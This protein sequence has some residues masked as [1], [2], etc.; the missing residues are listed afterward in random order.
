V[1]L[2]WALQGTEGGYGAHYLTCL[3]EVETLSTV[4]V[5]SNAV[6]Q[7]VGN[8]WRALLNL[9]LALQGNLD[10]R[11]VVWMSTYPVDR[12]SGHTESCH[13]APKQNYLPKMLPLGV[14]LDFTAGLQSVDIVRWALDWLCNG[15]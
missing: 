7:S 12:V 6:Y 13:L 11:K 9:A 3:D 14:V 4:V 5:Y 2:G 15:I 1:S 10:V 8:E